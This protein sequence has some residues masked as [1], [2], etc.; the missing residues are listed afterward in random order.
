[1]SPQALLATA[2]SGARL[3]VRHRAALRTSRPVARIRAGL[4]ARELDQLPSARPKFAPQ[5]WRAW[6]TAQLTGRRRGLGAVPASP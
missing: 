2:V 3:A 5:P 4:A 6:L 1:M